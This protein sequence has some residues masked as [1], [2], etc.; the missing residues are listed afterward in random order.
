MF[1]NKPVRDLVITMV[2]VA[3][4]GMGI[5]WFHYKRINDS[6]DPRIKHAR[7]LYGKYDNFTELS[8]YDSIFLLMDTI[9]SI[10][11]S[12]DHYKNSY[13]KAVLY[14]NRAAA[15]LAMSMQAGNDSLLSARL[16]LLESSEKSALTSINIIQ[17]WNENFDQ[18][19]ETVIRDLIRTGFLKGMDEYDAKEKERYLKYRVK[20]L[21]EAQVENSR[22]LSVAYTNLGMV[23]RYQKRYDSAA[24]FYKKAVDLWDRNLTAENNLNI[25]LNRPQKKRTLIQKLFPPN[26]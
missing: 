5:A 9:E 3:I 14:N 13:E 24:I 10:Y 25:L 26:K 1:K 6:I 8:S 12:T 15:Y 20:E 16:P 2:V 7:V 19:E 18:K 22:R 11:N 21:L 17:N 23:K 4:V